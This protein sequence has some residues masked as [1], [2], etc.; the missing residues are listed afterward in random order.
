MGQRRGGTLLPEGAPGGGRGADH[1]GPYRR[2]GA[3][4]CSAPLPRRRR[5]LAGGPRGADAGHTASR[6]VVFD[7]GGALRP[8]RPVAIGSGGPGE[9]AQPGAPPGLRVRYQGS[10]VTGRGRP[11]ATGHSGWA[12]LHATDLAEA[13]TEK[14]LW[15][16]RGCGWPYG[17]RSFYRVTQAP[18]GAS[19]C[20]RCFPDR[21][22]AP[23]PGSPIASSSGSSDAESSSS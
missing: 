23:A 10:G 19:W 17:I 7:G 6:P 13:T 3:D 20:L 12:R 5:G 1:D 8:G 18:E 11:R 15:K 2:R 9:G 14:F 4:L 16:A 21:R 22:E